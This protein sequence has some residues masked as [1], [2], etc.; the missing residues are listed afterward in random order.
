[1]TAA[2]TGSRHESELEDISI[3]VD[4]TPISGGPK[5]G[6]PT[7][8]AVKIGVAFLG[9]AALCAVFLPHEL[10]WLELT[11][12]AFAAAAAIVLNVIPVGEWMMTAGE[13]FRAWSDLL[14]TAE[15][16]ELKV[17]DLADD[18]NVPWSA[19]RNLVQLLW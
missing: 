8:K 11:I 7:N 10:K 2:C 1:V 19:P 15:R 5:N 18:A 3:T 14:L 13:M 6:E 17:I 16:L 4:G 9:V 12:A